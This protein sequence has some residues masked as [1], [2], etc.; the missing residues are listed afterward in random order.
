M[1]ETD[2]QNFLLDYETWDKDFAIG[3]AYELGMVE[4]LTDQQWKVIDY[5]QN[6]F[7]KTRFRPSLYETCKAMGLNAKSLHQLFPSGY[8][9]GACLLAGIGHIGPWIKSHGYQLPE[10]RGA[11]TEKSGFITKR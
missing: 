5:I 4:G 8:L 10:P 6:K 1:Y 2:D 11:S 7:E 3:M 9:R